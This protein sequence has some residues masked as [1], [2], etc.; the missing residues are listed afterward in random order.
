M[1]GIS[2]GLDCP[3]G[4]LGQVR[5]LVDYDYVLIDKASKDPAYLNYFKQSSRPKLLNSRV[6]KEWVPVSLDEMKKVWDVL[7]G[8]VISRDWLWEPKRTFDAYEESCKAFG[9]ENVIGVM[10]GTSQ[11]DIDTCLGLYGNKIALPFDV[12]SAK[13]DSLQVKICRRI[14]LVDALKHKRIHLLGLTSPKELEFYRYPDSVESLNTGLP[15]L[16][17][18]QGKKIEGYFEDKKDSSYHG[19]DMDNPPLSFETLRLVRSN[20]R[21]LRNLLGG[22]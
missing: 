14:M 11:E 9:Q 20:I 6:I 16:L 4:W 10:Q 1:Q 18:L 12:G 19:I 13:E 3:R 8:V 15:I 7:G 21:F 5:L 2:L 17:A 22:F